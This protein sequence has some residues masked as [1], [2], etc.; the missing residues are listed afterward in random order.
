MLNEYDFNIVESR[1]SGVTVARPLAESTEY[2][3]LHLEAGN[4]K[5]LLTSIPAIA[6]YLYFTKYNWAYHTQEE[7]NA[8]KGQ[9]NKKRLW[10]TGKGLDRSMIINHNMYT[11]RYAKDY[12]IDGPQ[13]EIQDGLMPMYG[14]YS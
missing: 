13:F 8:C 11:R 5:M 6:Q 4:E 14:C 9:V 2:N 12:M 1:T 7:L 3:L 10:P